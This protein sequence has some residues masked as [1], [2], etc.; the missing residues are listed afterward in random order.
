[1]KVAFQHTAL[2]FSSMFL[3]FLPMGYRSSTFYSNTARTVTANGQL[4]EIAVV[5]NHKHYAPDLC[6]ELFP[7]LLLFLN[8]TKPIQEHISD[9]Q[10]YSG[11]SLREHQIIW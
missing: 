11:N 2:E 7:L 4:C 1:M 9:C 8:L 5:M 10:K 3:K 6:E